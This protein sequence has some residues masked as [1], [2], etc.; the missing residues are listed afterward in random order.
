MQRS[1]F[2]LFVGGEGGNVFVHLSLVS[3]AFVRGCERKVY[4]AKWT[5]I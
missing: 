1:S 5:V 4:S 2:F 3:A